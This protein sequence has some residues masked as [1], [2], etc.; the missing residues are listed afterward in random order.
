MMLYLLVR[1]TWKR[2]VESQTNK[3]ETERRTESKAQID[4]VSTARNFNV[5]K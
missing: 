5:E 2:Y 3:L 4:I 1:D